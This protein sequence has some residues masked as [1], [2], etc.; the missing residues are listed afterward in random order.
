M[1]SLIIA[2]ALL[3][4]QSEPQMALIRSVKFEN[5]KG[6]SVDDVASRLRDRGVRVAVEQPYE[7]AQVESARKVLVELL[8]ER[9]RKGARVEAN[10]RRIPPA[11]VEVT[12]KVAKN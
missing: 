3:F 5:F 11:S 7:P 10:V 4:A 9:G 8:E 6:I 1:K 2:A 12:F